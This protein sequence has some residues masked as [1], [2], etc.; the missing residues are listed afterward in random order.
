MP[1][2]DIEVGDEPWLADL[3]LDSLKVRPSE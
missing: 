1:T 3:L 2:G